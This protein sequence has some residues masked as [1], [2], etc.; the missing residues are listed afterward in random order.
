M[1]GGDE[2]ASITSLTKSNEL[3]TY[4]LAYFNPEYILLITAIVINDGLLFYIYTIKFNLIK[5]T[6]TVFY[7]TTQWQCS[8]VACPCPSRTGRRRWLG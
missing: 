3:M 5:C 8:S 4:P 7:F 6:R 2:I 1:D